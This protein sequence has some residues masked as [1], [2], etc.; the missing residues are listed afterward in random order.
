[1]TPTPNQTAA[2]LAYLADGRWHTAR[3]IEAATG[4]G[5]RLVRAIAETTGRIIGLVPGYK[6]LDLA[7][8]AEREHA[9]KALIS[10]ARKL[11]A[12]AKKLAPEPRA[13]QAE[14]F[15]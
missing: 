11:E 3:Q 1:M 2:V 15:G 7:T 6:R 8:Q 14:L 5:P 13:E 4:V 10:R 9:R 12:R